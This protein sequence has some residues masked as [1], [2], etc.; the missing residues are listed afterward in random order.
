MNKVYLN[1]MDI[2]KSSIIYEEINEKNKNLF[3][4]FKKNIDSKKYIHG[5]ILFR[6]EES[7]ELYDY[8]VIKY[9]KSRNL[10]RL[11]EA[12]KKVFDKH[13]KRV[14]KLARDLK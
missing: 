14:R 11:Y 6:D 9:C 4:K 2:E 8:V 5:A 10:C 13:M 3:E 7:K 1:K 12:E